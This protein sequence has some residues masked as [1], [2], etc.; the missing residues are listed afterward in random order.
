MVEYVSQDGLHRYPVDTPIWRCPA[1]GQP[2]D[3]T[4]GDGL[5]PGDIVASDFSLW[6]YGKAIRVPAEGRVSLG[7]GLTPLVETA[8]GGGRPRIK[9]EYLA[10]SGSFKDRGM[11]VLVSY[12]KAHG[13]TEVMLDSSGNA[14]ASLACYAAAGGLQARLMVPGYTSPAKVAQIRVYGA[15]VE[16]VPGTRQDCAAAALK[17]AEDGLFYASH[18]WQPFFVEGTKTLAF[19]IWEQ[20]GFAV[21][22]NVVIPVGYGSNLM[23]CHLGFA[24]LLKRGAIARV[25]RL[26]AAQPANCAALHAAF[27]AGGAVAIEAKPTVAEGIANSKLVR[28]PENLAAL[29]ETGGGT[30]AVAE[31]AILPA[32][33]ALARRGFFVEPSS[34]VAGAGYRAL[35]ADGTIAADQE[36]VIVLTG[37]GLKSAD[38]LVG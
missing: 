14:A 7:E 30:V 15:E 38:A 18:N 20:Y 28:V 25:P 21:P 24:E 37:N 13:V 36:T 27:A 23:G 5:D 26:F 16:L 34:A 11:A 19:E 29:R 35:V 31:E 22:D 33:H 9:C 8:L 2:V 32:M 17:L 4:P 6:R 10:P 1:T 12:L 3:L